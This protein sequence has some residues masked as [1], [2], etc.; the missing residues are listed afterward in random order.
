LI[1]EVALTETTIEDLRTISHKDYDGNVISKWFHLKTVLHILT[2]VQSILIDPILLEIG[3]NVLSIPFAPS[4]PQ[5]RVP[6][7]VDLHITATATDPVCHTKKMKEM[8]TDVY[9]ITIWLR[10]EW[11]STN[12]LL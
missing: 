10:C 7:I 4:T 6:A 11:Q 9:S 12:Q 5:L 2:A 1:A 8:T 3:L